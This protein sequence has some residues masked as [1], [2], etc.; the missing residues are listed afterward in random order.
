[1]INFHNISCCKLRRVT[2]ED[3][4]KHKTLLALPLF[5]LMPFQPVHADTLT[6][7]FRLALSAPSTLALLGNAGRIQLPSGN[8]S[9]NLPDQ[10][11]TTPYPVTIQGIHLSANYS[12]EPPTVGASPN[13]WLIR[14]SAVNAEL[15]IDSINATQDIV[16]EQNGSTLIIHLNASC[17]NVRLA[18]APGATQLSATI[19][20]A[21][22]GNR[23]VYSLDQFSANWAPGAWQIVSLNCTGPQG[24]GD[25]VAQNIQAQ[26]QSINP[27]I[28]TIQAQL[29][30]Q[31]AAASNQ[32]ASWTLQAPGTSGA[33][34]TLLPSSVEFQTDGS[35][36][37]SGTATVSFPR[38]N[39]T[40]CQRT[41]S[42]TATVLAPAD[43][44]SLPVAAIEGLVE[45]AYLDGDLIST[46]TSEQFTAFQSLLGRPIVKFFVWP[47]L[48]RYNRND[49]FQFR[50]SLTQDPGFGTISSPAGGGLQFNLTTSLM[51]SVYSPEEAGLEHYVDF[52]A[53][54]NGTATLALQGGVLTYRQVGIGGISYTIDPEYIARHHPKRRIWTSIIG[55]Y[56]RG[57][58]ANTGLTYTLP[59]FQA[60]GGGL[61]LALDSA[62]L[63]GS[64]VVL[65]LRIQGAASP[66]AA[67]IKNLP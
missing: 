4:M 42:A 33:S 37:A 59:V 22:Q 67:P 43:S 15:V 57:F 45:C 47:H 46:F 48:L 26:L 32:P 39:G 20:V 62:S 2:S 52:R 11:L 6:T 44:L 50:A 35:A 10:N 3:L 9:T 40:A 30:E 54:V 66:L 24:F 5:L 14:S 31:L 49:I 13:Q 56:F 18:L 7:P 16:Q 34:L 65:G 1:M 61:S 12:L 38:L 36:R 51:L 64:D 19:G 60:P 8:L 23:V 25:I 29:S 55:R 53:P 27:F 17:N 63:N 21:L 58:L 28:P 41:V